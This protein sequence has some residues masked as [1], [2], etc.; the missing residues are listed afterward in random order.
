MI[1]TIHVEEKKRLV[2]VNIQK[3][4]IVLKR[5]NESIPLKYLINLIMIYTIYV[6]EKN[7]SSL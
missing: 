1:Y 7:V 2:I 4:L 5:V 6:E 3:S